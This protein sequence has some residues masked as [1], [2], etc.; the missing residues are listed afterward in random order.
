VLLFRTLLLFSGQ[1]VQPR[2]SHH[3][4]GVDA[5]PASG[6]VANHRRG[7][8]NASLLDGDRERLIDKESGPSKYGMRMRGLLQG[9]RT[10]GGLFSAYQR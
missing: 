4:S 2:A 5:L 9:S 6:S 7:K 1:P 8:R 10:E 3:G